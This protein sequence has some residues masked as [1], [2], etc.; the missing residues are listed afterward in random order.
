MKVV[1]LQRDSARSASYRNVSE[2]VDRLGGTY[3][4][5][6]LPVH[7]EKTELVVQWGFKPTVG[8]MSAIAA[9]IPY[10]IIDLGYHDAHRTVRYSVSF[11]GFNGTSWRDPKV[12]DRA[13]R[14]RPDYRDWR[15]GEGENV[16]V[17]GQMPNDQSLRGQDIDAW[18]GRAAIAA[19]DAF[20]L[21]VIKRPH[22]KMLNP[23]EP[24]PEP[25]EEALDKAY[26]VVT[27]TSTVGVGSVLAGVPTIVQHPGS[28]AYPM[29]A[30]DM[31][32]RTPHGREAWLHELSWR[33][34]S[35]G[36]GADLDRLAAYIVEIYP[37][38][39]D[40]PLDSPRNVL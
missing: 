8:L 39:R 16:L 33:E 18:M 29:A 37:Q 5:R 11:N 17:I 25:L 1:G 22:P 21:P 35:W 3:Q 2:L 19:S 24:A 31:T 14:P 26:A 38:L 7:P 30:H 28:V 20:G 15:S 27:W 40:A 34:W 6:E 12:L 4:R 10:V 9:G 13:S 32:L 36:F 23:W